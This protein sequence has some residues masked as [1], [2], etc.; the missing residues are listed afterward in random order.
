MA[1]T[2]QMVR[3]EALD[4]K[5]VAVRTV[6]GNIVRRVSNGTKEWVSAGG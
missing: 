3:A 4:R 1:K 6:R 2:L 5:E